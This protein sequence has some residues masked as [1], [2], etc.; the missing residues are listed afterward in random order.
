MKISLNWIKKFTTVPA[1]LSAKRLGELLTLRTAEVEGVEEEALMFSEIVVGK[2]LSIQ[3]HPN[4]DK[5]KVTQVDIGKKKVQIV[6]GG[7]NLNVGMHVAVALPGASVL[8]HGEGEPVVLEET[9][10]RGEKSFGMICAEEEIYLP[11][12]TPQEGVAIADL[13]LIWKIMGLKPSAAGTPLAQAL[14]RTDIIFDVD[15]KSLTHRPDLWSHYGMAREFSAFL[16]AKLKPFTTKVSFPKKGTKVAVKLDKPGLA[17]RFLSVVITGIKVAPSPEWMQEQLKAVGIRPVSNIVDITNYV[18]LELGH[19]LHAFDRRVVG[20][21]TFVV[22]TAK[23]GEVLETLDHKKRELSTEDVLVTNGKTALALAGVMGG[24]NSEITDST[25]EV[26]LEVATWDPTKIRK[27]SQRHN[28]R[29]DAA[30]RF[31]K[32]LDPEVAGAAFNRAVELILELCPTAQLAGPATD[33]YA[34]K[35]TSPTV[36]LD[37]ARTSRKIGAEITE[38]AAT[39]YLTRLSFKV[40]KGSKKGFLKVTVPTFRATKDVSIEEDLVEEVARMYGYENIVPV[41]PSLPI[42]LPIPN[43]ERRREHEAR[44][45]LS[46]GLGFMENNCYSFYSEEEIADYGLD[47]ALH[48]KV[49]NPLS[50]DQTHMRT[51]LVPNLL[52]AVIKNREEQKS[53]H[54]YELGRSYIKEA[55]SDSAF[56]R[57]EK[58]ICGIIAREKGETF[59]E[60]LG[61]LRTFLERFEAPGSRVLESREPVPYAHPKAS[62]DFISG[63]T[64][65]ATLFDLH[66]AIAQAKGLS[67]SATIFELNLSQLVAL[68]R[69]KF[70]YSPLPRFPGIELDIS[71]LV[72]RTTQSEVI[73]RLLKKAGQQLIEEVELI[74]IFEGGSLAA[75][76]KSFT[77]RV[78]LRSAERTL[79]DDDLHQTQQAI[80]TAVEKAGYSVR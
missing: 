31:E 64:K 58:F 17:R 67:G 55:S 53:V 21:D 49:A 72:E 66:P 54:L 18:M 69:R 11:T 57:E 62:A 48:L 28:L 41:L 33:V 60:L 51:T 32:S 16:K 47:T 26:V 73:L 29:S 36:Q 9:A 23:K 78:L 39:D 43:E 3:S 2:V 70:S 42:S 75:D 4:A 1:D 50:S 24:L 7:T 61:V 19:P 35:A 8:W 63:S 38:K 20:N 56:P 13:D 22:R 74:D 14:S 44:Q 15:N 30:Q 6:C 10:I 40:A 37:V 5:L 45:L 80:Y 68:G 71:V 12:M 65:I 46:L 27:T 76:K 25:T 79:T 59:Y 34:D 52:K 77:F